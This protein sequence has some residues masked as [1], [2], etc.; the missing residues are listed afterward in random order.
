MGFNSIGSLKQVST[1][2]SEPT[3][4]CSSSLMLR[5]YHSP[6]LHNGII[7]KFDNGKIIGFSTMIPNLPFGFWNVQQTAKTT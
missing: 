3:S 5:P 6:F 4:L 2:D 7:R 1:G